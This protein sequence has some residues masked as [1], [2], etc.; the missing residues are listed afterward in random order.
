MYLRKSELPVKLGR[1]F[2]VVYKTLYNKYYIDELYNFLFIQPT[3]WVA[4]KI[5]VGF[6]DAKI[7]EGVVNG[8]PRTI[9]NFSQIFRK[10][11]SGITN[12]YAIFMAAGAVFIIALAILLRG[13]L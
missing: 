8:V 3:L 6:T 12:N 5:L 7:I 10:I 11:Q 1:A 4:R 9:G 2:S 13:S